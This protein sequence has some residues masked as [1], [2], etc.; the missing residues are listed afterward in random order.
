MTYHDSNIP[1]LKKIFY[2]NPKERKKHLSYIKNKRIKM[3]NNR[4][5][6]VVS[7][8]IEKTP[9]DTTGYRTQDQRVAK[10]APSPSGHERS[11]VSLATT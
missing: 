5:M 3:I 4:S 10:L 6:L 8:N 11:I 2:I 1:H 9:H 7:K